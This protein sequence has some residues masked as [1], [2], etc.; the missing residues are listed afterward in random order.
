MAR[1]PVIH[2]GGIPDVTVREPCRKIYGFDYG[3]GGVSSYASPRLLGAEACGG[4][5]P[6][7]S[8][9]LTPTQGD[10]PWL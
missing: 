10:Q 7:N 6:W 4:P 2:E 1:A 8:P 3:G 9:P 5:S